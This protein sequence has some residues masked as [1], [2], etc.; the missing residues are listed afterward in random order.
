MS[1]QPSSPN[2]SAGASTNNNNNNNQ[3]P[4]SPTN[5]NNNNQAKD[6]FYKSVGDYTITRMLGSGKFGEVRVA[7]HNTTKEYCAV[8]IV[9]RTKL[10]SKKDVDHINREIT[11]M[12]MLRHPHVVQLKEALQTAN[13]IY[14]FMELPF[15]RRSSAPLPSQAPPRAGLRSGCPVSLP[16][17]GR[18][19]RA[20]PAQRCVAACRALG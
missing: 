15:E 7:Q 4:G 12:K 5:N 9:Q 14:L 17:R 10:K 20:S 2:N 16:R 11:F 19:S 18:H 1:Q 6:L 13:N 3:Q 8:K